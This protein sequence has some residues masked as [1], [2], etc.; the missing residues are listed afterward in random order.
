MNPYNGF[1]PQQRSKALRW[2][3][4]EIADGRRELPTICDVCGQTAGQIMAH[5]EDYSEPFGDHIGQFGLC[6]RCHMILHCRMKSPPAFAAY[7]RTLRKGVRF[8]P[9][10]ARNFTQFASD[11]L[12][13]TSA[14]ETEQATRGP[15]PGFEALLAVGRRAMARNGVTHPLQLP[16]EE[17]IDEQ[18]MIFLTQ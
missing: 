5:S 12:R 10:Y 13:G 3:N 11:H 7:C 18:A 4:R 2:F 8:A 9:M 1:T 6:Y 14:P 15:L 17:P 16:G